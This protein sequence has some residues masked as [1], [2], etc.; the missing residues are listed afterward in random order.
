MLATSNKSH[1]CLAASGRLV[2]FAQRH[3]FYLMLPNGALARLKNPLHGTIGAVGRHERYEDT[4]L[5]IRVKSVGSAEKTE[6]LQ[7]S[8]G[9]SGETG[10][11]Q[12][13]VSLP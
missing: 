12:S 10:G 13:F 7:R 8:P 3:L 11:S 6:T 5:L 1:V 9:E 2:L 4:P